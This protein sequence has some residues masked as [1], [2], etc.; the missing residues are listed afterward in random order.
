MSPL[1]RR[2]T[3]LALGQSAGKLA[4]V[5]VALVLVRVLSPEA[6]A[7]SALLLSVYAAATAL[8]TLSL[9]QSL[10][11]FLPGLA[12]PEKSRLV[13]QTLVLLAG[14]GVLTGLLVGLA[15]PWVLEGAFGHLP[16]FA[17]LGLACALEIP[18]LVAAPLLVADDRASTA[19]LFD[20]AMAVVQ[21]LAIAVAAL[22]GFGPVGIAM[23]LCAYASVR[24]V[25]VIRLARAVAP[26]APA[27]ASWARAKAYVVHALPLMVAL[28]V[29]VL[30]KHV[31]KWIV[32]AVAPQ[33]F[34]VYAVAAQELPF[35]AVLPYAL[36]A[37]LGAQMSLAFKHGRIQQ[38]R[39]LWL[40]QTRSMAKI[41]VPLTIVLVLCAP[42]LVP[43]LFTDAYT[44]AVLPFQ[45]FGLITLHRVAEYGL[46]LRAQGR[47]QA[48]FAAS[49][50]LLALTTLLGVPLAW[51]FGA[52]GAA[53]AALLSQ[54]GAWL[55][56]LRPLARGFEMRFWD[57][58]PFRHYL[59]WLARAVASALPAALI[60][61]LWFAEHGRGLRL[62]LKVAVFLAGMGL[63]CVRSL[64]L[65]R[66][67]AASP[68]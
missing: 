31:D 33:S 50:C 26:A 5:V 65:R 10:I 41:V 17:L 9:P 18:S 37:T 36:S 66:V 49:V 22:A 8:G 25:L 3:L 28:G 48:L 39:D 32:A 12:P 43:L 42:Q 56:I 15:L 45:L 51:I 58:F 19:G 53:A 64:P 67:S 46:V 14:A 40:M 13:R 30:T 4:Q 38:A 60:A 1:A 11:F 6:W 62:A 34:G 63:L 47:P 55:F 68:P 16:A 7:T 20:G 24:L 44:A 52:T 57:V 21:V 59:V 61:D 35:V 54:L 23:A 27:P 2:V 29:S